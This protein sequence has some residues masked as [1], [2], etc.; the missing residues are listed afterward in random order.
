MEIGA[1]VLVVDPAPPT[2]LDR[3]CV[4]ELLGLTPREGHLAVALA[5]G[6]TVSEVALEMGRSVKTVRRHLKR[7]AILRG[8]IGPWLE[9]CLRPWQHFVAW[10]A[11]GH[12]KGRSEAEEPWLDAPMAS[13]HSAQVRTDRRLRP[14][15]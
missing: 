5:E 9:A 1:L 3:E 14:N 8:A 6:R 4:G 10:T 15:K 2:G 7:I 12:P 13:R 11:A